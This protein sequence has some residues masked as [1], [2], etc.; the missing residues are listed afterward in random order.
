M[1]VAVKTAV[2][3]IVK[4]F[5]VDSCDLLGWVRNHRLVTLLIEKIGATQQKYELTPSL[6]TV[7][8]RSI[9]PTVL[10]V[11]NVLL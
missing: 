6:N 7:S 8:L 2:L 9:L 11:T 4:H 1:S 3:K 5:F 10:Q